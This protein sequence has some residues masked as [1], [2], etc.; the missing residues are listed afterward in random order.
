MTESQFYKAAAEADRF[1]VWVRLTPELNQSTEISRA[2]M[3][4]LADTAFKTQ[5]KDN[6]L[7]GI[8][9]SFAPSTKENTLIIGSMV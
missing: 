9:A 1:F 2:A 6:N 4:K 3:I 5:A 7:Y 8:C